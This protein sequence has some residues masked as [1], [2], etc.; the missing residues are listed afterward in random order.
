M[1]WWSV[2]GRPG[3]MS[4]CLFE[5]GRPGGEE[6]E[7]GTWLGRWECVWHGPSPWAPPRVSSLGDGNVH[8]STNERRRRPAGPGSSAFVRIL[9]FWDLGWGAGGVAFIQDIWFWRE[10]RYQP[11]RGLH[12]ATICL[13][14]DW[15]EMMNYLVRIRRSWRRSDPKLFK[16]GGGGGATAVSLGLGRGWARSWGSRSLASATRQLPRSTDAHP[17]HI[18]VTISALPKNASRSRDWNEGPRSRK[19]EKEKCSTEQYIKRWRRYKSA[20]TKSTHTNIKSAR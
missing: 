5:R 8:D 13:D 7:R 4:L 14:M 15:M 19:K 9:P 17:A 3:I 2:F 16:T 20:A 12:L 1:D 18:N 10:A 6:K 11:Y